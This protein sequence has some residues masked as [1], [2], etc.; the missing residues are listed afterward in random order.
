MSKT[1]LPARGRLL[2]VMAAVAVIA[3]LASAAWYGVEAISSQPIKR[4][5]IAGAIGRIAPA[6][7]DSFAQGV[8]GASARGASLDS[9]R[10]AA[11]RIPWVRDAAVRRIFPDAV[12]ITFR[13]HEPFAR[14]EEGAL[15]ST[16]GEVFS[17]D[18][19]G[20]LPRFKGP[21]EGSA[22]AMAREYPAI[23]AALAPLSAAVAELRL[24]RRGA[25]QVVLELPADRPLPSPGP[26]PKG[27]GQLTLE[28]GRG[29]IL[30]RLQRFA[31]AW[32]RVVAQGVET[33]HADLR[34]AN[35]FAVKK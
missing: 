32:P 4:V 3:L 35:G 23:V 6:H 11:R 27:E 9:I 14:W 28:L 24:S 31:A 21:D 19:D 18:Y 10:E 5:V 13:V 26:S 22:S 2:P 34:Y 16:R 7:L 15:V 20:A 12:E 17:A 29:E 30:A 25:W 33:R 8:H 1:A